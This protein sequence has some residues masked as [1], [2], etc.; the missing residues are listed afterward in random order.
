[1]KPFLKWAGGKYRLLPKIMASLPPG[2]RLIEPFLGSAALFL[3]T[4][5]SQYLL[6]DANGDLISTYDLL[7]KE[8]K[9]FINYCREFFIPEYNNRDSYVEFRETFNHTL[10][11]R[12]KSALFIYLNRHCYNGLCR[13]NSIGKFNTPFGTYKNPYFPETEMLHFYTHSKN[14]DFRH[15]NFTEILSQAAPG[16]VIYCD[17]PYVP[18]SKTANFTQY[19]QEKFTQT[20]QKQ[21]A[22]FARSLANKGIPVIISNHAN[23][24]IMDLYHDADIQL[25]DVKRTISRD[26]KNRKP[27]RE[28][29]AVFKP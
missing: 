8:G 21:L 29:L 5:Y 9:T 24:Y 27:T 7:K 26:I 14:A 20:Q 23:D 3:N 16:D 22:D 11:I 1:M 10:D 13:Y 18:L 12:L 4:Q 17:P 6:A 2:S 15:A 28:I 25:F 19:I